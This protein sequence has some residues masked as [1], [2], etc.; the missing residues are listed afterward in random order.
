MKKPSAKEREIAEKIGLY[1]LEQNDQD[2][3]VT[4]KI[5]RDLEITNIEV[6]DF[7]IHIYTARPGLLIGR[8]GQNIDGLQ[9]LFDK[10]IDI[11]ESF[12]WAAYITPVDWQTEFA[13]E[14]ENEAYYELGEQIRQQVLEQTTHE[15][16]QIDD[17]FDGR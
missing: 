14:Q 17:Y 8:K 3:T 4:A 9:K 1:F 13:L 15:F 5:I 16:D 11:I 7:Y 12:T 10:K 6:D 2:Y